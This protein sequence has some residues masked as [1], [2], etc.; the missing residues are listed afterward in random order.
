MTS[1]VCRPTDY[2]VSILDNCNTELACKGYAS[3]AQSQWHPRMQVNQHMV[4]VKFRVSW[5]G[6]SGEIMIVT[7]FHC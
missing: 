5:F 4:Y 3:K 1:C 6:C 2:E 7:D